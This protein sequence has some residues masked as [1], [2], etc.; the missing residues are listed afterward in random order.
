MLSILILAVFIVSQ[1]WR[2]EWEGVKHWWVI[3]GG[4]VTYSRI[5]DDVRSKSSVHIG[6]DD[7]SGFIVSSHGQGFG[8][9]TGVRRRGWATFV[10]L[11]LPFIAVTVPT[12][13][14]WWI[15]PRRY[16]EGHCPCGYNLTGNVSGTCPEC[17]RAALPYRG[18]EIP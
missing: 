10:P 18:S 4:Y 6:R 8:G 11:W 3:A 7:R 17:G 13:V 5:P 12:A 14:F 1:H 2:L 16:P 9:L 15:D